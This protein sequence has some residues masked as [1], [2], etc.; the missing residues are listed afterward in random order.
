M[1]DL[2]Q[3]ILRASE[4][5][6]R[7]AELGGIGEPTDEHILEIA[8]IFSDCATSNRACKNEGAPA[9]NEFDAGWR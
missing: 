2:Q 5:K 1:T 4:M 3:L 6:G 7:L 8:V 9:G